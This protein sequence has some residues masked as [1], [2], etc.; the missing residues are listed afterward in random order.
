M[1]LNTEEDEVFDLLICILR[2]NERREWMSPVTM[3]SL[4]LLSSEICASEDILT[5]EYRGRNY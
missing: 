1:R 5:I 4:D 2:D 3:S